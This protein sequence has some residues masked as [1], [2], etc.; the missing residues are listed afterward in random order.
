METR[1]LKI[2]TRVDEELQAAAGQRG[3]SKKRFA[4]AAI[5]FF[6]QSQISPE[7]YHPGREFDKVELIRKS[8]ERIIGRIDRQE[9]EVL[10][11][12][13]AEV[14]RNQV[15]LQAM[16]NLL[17]E[18]AV[19]P[20]RQ[21]AVAQRLQASIREQLEQLAAAADGKPIAS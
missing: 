16:M 14:L 12:L 9:R 1:Q 18:V 13:L 19:E 6:A 15:A 7:G 11:S 5:L 17:V 3:L 2:S 10:D 8:T 20:D 4:E 21:E